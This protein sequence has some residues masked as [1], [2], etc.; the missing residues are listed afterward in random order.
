MDVQNPYRSPNESG[1]QSEPSDFKPIPT[2]P[3]YAVLI[4]VGLMFV[5]LLRILAIAVPMPAVH[6]PLDITVIDLFVILVGG[7]LFTSALIWTVSNG[8]FVESKQS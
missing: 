8:G 4:G 3:R 2:W 7:I 1:D 6:F 5:P